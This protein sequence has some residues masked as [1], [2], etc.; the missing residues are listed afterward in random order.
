MRIIYPCSHLWSRA[1]PW[2]ISCQSGSFP[3]LYAV[4]PPAP[5]AVLAIVLAATAV[6]VMLGCTPQVAMATVLAG[7]LTAAELRLLLS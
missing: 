1:F 2:R 5:V 3:E 6:L 4:R 7:G